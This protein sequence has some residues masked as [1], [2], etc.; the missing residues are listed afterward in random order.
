VS[1]RSRRPVSELFGPMEKV[2]HASAKPCT[3]TF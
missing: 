2:R 1:A 3:S